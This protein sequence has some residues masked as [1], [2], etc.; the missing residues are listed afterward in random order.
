MAHYSVH[1][2][3][4]EP[5]AGALHFL[6]DPL[7]C[8][9]LGVTVADC[10][11]GWTGKAHDHADGGHEEVYVLVEGQATLEVEGEPV[12][13]TPGEAVR[14]DPAAERQLHNGDDESTL[15]IAGAP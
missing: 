9:E 12:S 3:E 15:L 8:A 13:M 4:I 10:P 2:E 6:R 5:V 7:G 1:Y 14:V 11:P